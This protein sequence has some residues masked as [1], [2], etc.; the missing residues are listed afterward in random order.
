M[1]IHRAMDRAILEPLFADWPENLV[2]STLDGCMGEAYVNDTHTAAQVVNADF[3]F[4]AG[5]T[6]C[7]EAQTLVAH[8]PEGF[9][10]DTFII[11]AK[12]DAWYPLIEQQFGNRAARSERY[13]IRKDVH[14]FNPEK[15]RGFAQTLPEGIELLQMD[16]ER[17]RLAQ[18]IEWAT[19]FVSQFADEADFLARGLGV[20]ALRNGEL[21]AGASSYVVFKGGIEVEIDTRKDMRRQGLA[22]AC[23]A[24]LVLLCLERG[25][26]PSWDA[27]NRDS[28]ALAEKLGY[29]FDHPYPIYKVALKG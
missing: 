22:T 6:Q 23:G 15:L 2:R 4:L 29:V 25:L 7:A 24:M 8:V 19:D 13:A 14:H 5:D 1:G 21:L 28:V 18:R 20:M 27:A 11:A 9:H 12:E 17:Y 16:G 10:A 3:S 26:Y